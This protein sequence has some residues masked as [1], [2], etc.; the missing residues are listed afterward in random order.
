MK[1][2]TAKL[3]TLQMFAGRLAAGSIGELVR[4]MD[5]SN[6]SVSVVSIGP[7]GVQG[8]F[9]TSFAI[10]AAA[11]V[12]DQL[13]ANYS[14]GNYSSRFAFPCNVALQDPVSVAAEAEHC[15]KHL[16]G[17]GAIVGGYPN[18]GS[19]N[20]VIYV[21]DPSNDVFWK[22]LERL[23]VPL[24]LHPRM[25]PHDQQRVYKVWISCS[26]TLGL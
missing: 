16:G 23:N 4:Q 1:Y 18:N 9:N 24:Y 8:I 12:N 19:V 5:L 25:P 15:V 20:N 26:L 17:V 13:H 10:T 21:D 6:I 22:K 11:A 3:S 2:S 7:P 14:T